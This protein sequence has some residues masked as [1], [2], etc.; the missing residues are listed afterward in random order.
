MVTQNQQTSEKIAINC[1]VCNSS[2][3]NIKYQPQ[4]DIQDPVKLYGAAS[5]IPGTQTIVVCRECGMIYENPRFSEEVI[6]QG[7]MSANDA[8]HDSQYLMRVNS[9]YRSLNSLQAHLPPAGTKVLDVGTAGGGFLEAAKKF[10]YDAVGLEPSRFLV[11]QGKRRGLNIEQ[12]TLDNHP[13]EPASFD[14][15]C[16]WDVLEHVVNPKTNLLKIRGLL[17]PGGVLLINY[18]DIGTWQAKLAGR[19]F[20]WLLSVHLHHFSQ[21]SIRKICTRTGFEVF[22]FQRYWQ[23]LEFGYLEDMAI[24]Y[25]IPL[26]KVLKQLTPKFIQKLPVPYYASQTTALARVKS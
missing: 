9:F 14:M 26:S 2:Q 21:E 19:R 25:K 12:G 23:T 20:W 24:H 7:Y 16:L 1:P 8:G 18:P 13:F 5:G 15:V 22:R 11:E 4:V 10:G 3:Y 17:K 6:L